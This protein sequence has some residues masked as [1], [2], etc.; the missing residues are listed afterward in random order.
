MSIFAFC[1]KKKF[2]GPEKYMAAGV[3][4][5]YRCATTAFTVALPLQLEAVFKSTVGI[6]DSATPS[7][8]WASSEHVAGV[9]VAIWS[10]IN[11]YFI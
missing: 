5:V 9:G 11:N 8:D 4:Y 10:K 3:V 1:K 6:A 7:V 2:V